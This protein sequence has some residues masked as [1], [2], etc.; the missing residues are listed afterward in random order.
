MAIV[1]TVSRSDFIDELGD[2][3]SYDAKNA[4]YDYF[5]EFSDDV[6]ETI[7]LDRVA[8]RCNWVEYSLEE[9]KYGFPECIVVDAGG[10]EDISLDEIY[11]Q[12]A[13]IIEVDK[14]TFLV[15]HS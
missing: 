1:K 5:E 9:L 15:Q 11:P 13:D 10:E 12:V 3:F 6:G 4:L 7:E 8:I 2:D 14:N